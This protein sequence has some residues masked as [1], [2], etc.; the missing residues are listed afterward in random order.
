MSTTQVHHDA[1]SPDRHIDP[2]ARQSLA[3]RHGFTLVE[4]LVVIVIIG[5]L[6]GIAI[7]AV[8]NVIATGRETALKVEIT[9]LADSVEQYNL[10]YGDY[11]PDMSSWTIA[12]RHLKKAFPRMSQRDLT[13]LYNMCHDGNGRFN[14]AAI[15]RSEAL[16]LFLGGFSDDAAYPLT[17]AGGPFECRLAQNN[18]AYTTTTNVADFQYNV[19]R[20]DAL[21]E[22]DVARLTI[23]AAA[24]ETGGQ[25]NSTDDG[26]LIPA[27]Q[28]DGR[29][30]PFVYF[31]SRTY[32]GIPD[33]VSTL[34]AGA[35]P[36]NGYYNP[37]FGGVRPYKTNVP[38]SPTGS[39]WGTEPD[40]SLKSWKFANDK[41]F[42]IIAAGTDDTFG[43]LIRMPMTAA[44]NTVA[45]NDLPAYFIEKTGKAMTINSNATSPQQT[46]ITGMDGFQEDGAVNGSEGN[47]HLDNITNFSSRTLE[48][49]LET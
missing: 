45:A 29:A 28:M 37:D 22:F 17:G 26:D 13:L 41:S 24:A 19:S 48:S 21:F 6:A 34:V 1:S 15:D 7:P 8:T 16:V 9:Q 36:Y 42:Q 10:K 46:L 27:Y 18:A 11:P 25:V 40:A 43:T 5:I 2:A 35:N 14:P 32:G 47:A 23:N 4:I 12:Q 39:G 38:V 44:Q 33:A 3:A 30:A 31:E 49:D 20:N